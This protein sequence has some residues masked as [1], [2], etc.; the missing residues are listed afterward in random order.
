[1]SEQN[2]Y[3]GFETAPLRKIAFADFGTAPPAVPDGG[4]L[5][6]WDALAEW[7]PIGNIQEDA[8][9]GSLAAETV[10][11]EWLEENVDLNPPLA[12]GITGVVPIK[13]ALQSV[14]FSA[15]SVNED[16]LQIAS[17]W[18]D[19]DGVLHPN[20]TPVFRA[21][22]MEYYGVYFAYMPRVLVRASVQGGGV[23]DLAV[24]AFNCQVITTPDYPGGVS[25]HFY[26]Q[27]S[28]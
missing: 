5:I 4:D 25:Y 10:S 24:V 12:Q 1:M 7:T 20:V 11:T 2:P 6:D 21:M 18:T 17:L 13:N 22:L 14:S 27:E 16:I 9:A 26:Q 28:S 15:F 19:E 8:D 23:T 3:A